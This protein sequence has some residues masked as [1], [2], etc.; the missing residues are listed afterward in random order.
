VRKNPGS[1]TVTWSTYLARTLERE[2]I[3]FRYIARHAATLALELSMAFATAVFALGVGALLVQSRA[4]IVWIPIVLIGAACAVWFF[5]RSAH[6]TH[7]LLCETRDELNSRMG[8][9]PRAPQ[10]RHQVVSEASD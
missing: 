8:G 1:T 4:P 6:D 2:P 10:A 9:L 5:G 7:E 3:G